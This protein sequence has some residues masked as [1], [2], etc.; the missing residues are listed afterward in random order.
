MRLCAVS[1]PD[2]EHGSRLCAEPAVGDRWIPTG[3]PPGRG[4]DRSCT[5]V[6][7]AHAAAQDA[8][9]P[10]PLGP[11]APGPDGYRGDVDVLHGPAPRRRRGAPPA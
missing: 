9:H 4:D 6:C 1:V 8:A 5:S 3:R 2:A 7:A 10:E 11:P